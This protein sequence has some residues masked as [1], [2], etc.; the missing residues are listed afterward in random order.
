MNIKDGISFPATASVPFR[1][2]LSKRSRTSRSAYVLRESEKTG[3]GP[4]SL[5]G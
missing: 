2:W 1:V 5:H 4:E 3:G